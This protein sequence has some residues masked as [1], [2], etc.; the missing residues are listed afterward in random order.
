[1][2]PAA[3][4]AA[5]NGSGTAAHWQPPGAGAWPGAEAAGAGAGAGPT[6][7]A[8]PTAAGAVAWG[9]ILA[10]ME[11]PCLIGYVRRTLVLAPRRAALLL[12]LSRCGPHSRPCL[13]QTH[14]IFQQQFF[15]PYMPQ[16]IR[17]LC[18]SAVVH[19][20]TMSAFSKLPFAVGCVQDAGLIFLSAIA[21]KVP[22][23]SCTTRM[24]SCTAAGALP[25]A[26]SLQRTPCRCSAPPQPIWLPADS[27]KR[28]SVRNSY[29]TS[30]FRCASTVQQLL[31]PL[32]VAALPVAPLPSAARPKAPSAADLGP[33]DRFRSLRSL[34]AT[35]QVLATVLW[36]LSLATALLGLC[37]LAFGALRLG[38]VVQFLPTPVVQVTTLAFA[39]RFPLPVLSKPVPV[40]PTSAYPPNR[41]IW[42]SSGSSVSR[43]G[44]G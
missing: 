33:V 22:V 14:I 16:L 19:Q 2:L 26:F 35:T 11:I 29:C 5:S 7:Q 40:L 34:R 27:P 25:V 38:A 20:L 37:L 30:A 43:P 8:E 15:A 32:P 36:A 6:G 23:G 42:P 1:M 41:A 9:F 21:N 13:S 3:A 10:L 44:S 12:A 24:G 31:L 4:G 39:L 17:L 28:T 18:A